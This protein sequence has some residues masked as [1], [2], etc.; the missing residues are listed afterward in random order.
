MGSK[1]S[2]AHSIN[3]SIVFCESC[4]V[5]VHKKCQGMIDTDL[6]FK[7]DLCSYIQN[8]KKQAKISLERHFYKCLI[9]L[10]NGGAMKASDRWDDK[11]LKLVPR[12]KPDSFHSQSNPDSYFFPSKDWKVRDFY[13]LFCA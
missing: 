9:C 13:H 1:A 12:V 11:A 4:N 10:K 2:D 3:N 7:C 8:R 5:G 6:D